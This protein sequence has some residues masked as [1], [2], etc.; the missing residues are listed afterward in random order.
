MSEVRFVIGGAI[1]IIRENPTHILIPIQIVCDV[2]SGDKI[3]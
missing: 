3:K 1:Y 2:F